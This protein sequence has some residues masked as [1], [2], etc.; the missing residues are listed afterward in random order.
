MTGKFL[1][2]DVKYMKDLVEVAQTHKI[3]NIID[4]GETTQKIVSVVQLEDDNDQSHLVMVTRDFYDMMDFASEKELKA[5]NNFSNTVRR[6]TEAYSNKYKVRQDL[7]I[8]L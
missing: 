8:Q 2:K 4:V 5:Y 1:N 6:A 3:V 7:T